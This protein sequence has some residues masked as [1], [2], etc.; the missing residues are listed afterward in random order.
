[1]RAAGRGFLVGVGFDFQIVERCPADERDVTIDCVVT[2][3]R[4]VRCAQGAGAVEVR[5]AIMSPTIIVIIVLAA[6][7]GAAALAFVI[8]RASKP[9]PI[10]ESEAEK[11]RVLAAARADA[12]SIKREA[13]VQA[14]ET[15]QKIRA[16][17]DGSI[18][19]AAQELE[20]QAAELQAKGQALERRDRDLKGE[21]RG[22]R[23][24]GEAAAQPRAGGG[25]GGPARG[26][27]R[28]PRP[29]RGSRR[30]PG[31][32]PGEARKRLEDEVRDEARQDGGRRG[33]AIEDEA[34]A[35]AD[36]KRAGAS[37]HGDPA[38]RQRVRRRADRVGGA[39][40][41]PTT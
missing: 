29:R 7:A 35:E 36:E 41:R 24:Q 27:A 26:G 1:M 13:A 21:R 37:R 40:A 28:P 20:R 14:K 12:D 33:Q 34:R 31:C 3:T 17:A 11:Q 39:A 19:V 25:G 8:G 6:V 16:E 4:V 15:A 2:E 23:A 22:D 9:A 30:S 5:K 32:P 38:L 18:R 10:P